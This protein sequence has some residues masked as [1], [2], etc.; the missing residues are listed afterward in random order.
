[1]A[2]RAPEPPIT[3]ANAICGGHRGWYVWAGGHQRWHRDKNSSKA[4]KVRRSCQ[5]V[6]GVSRPAWQDRLNGWRLVRRSPLSRRVRRVTPRSRIQSRTRRGDIYV[7]IGCLWTSLALHGLRR[8]RRHLGL[9]AV[10]FDLRV[11]P[12]ESVNRRPISKRHLD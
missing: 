9:T 4:M 7:D 5:E 12:L 2:I 10:K 11:Y 6:D 1:M 8:A 3:T